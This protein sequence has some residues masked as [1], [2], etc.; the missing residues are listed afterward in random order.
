MGF[1]N[2]LINSCKTRKKY[3]K[4][5]TGTLLTKMIEFKEFVYESSLEPSASGGFFRIN[6]A[7]IPTTLASLITYLI[8]MLTNQY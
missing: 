6:L 5:E 8:V 7:S 2:G 3:E 1:Q 4:N